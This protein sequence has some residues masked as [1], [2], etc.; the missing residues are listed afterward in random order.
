MITMVTDIGKGPTSYSKCMIRQGTDL[1]YARC[2]IA[3]STERTSNQPVDGGNMEEDV[4]KF[5]ND[6]NDSAHVSSSAA[7]NLM[8]VQTP[9]RM[10]GPMDFIEHMRSRY[11]SLVS[12]ELSFIL[13]EQNA[14]CQ[15]EINTARANMQ[16]DMIKF[17]DKLMASIS[18]RCICCTARGFT[19]CPTRAVDTFPVDKLRTPV[20]QK[21]PSV[22]L[23]MSACKDGNSA[24]RF[25]GDEQ[26]DRQQNKRSR[27]EEGALATMTSQILQFARQTLQA[28]SE[29]FID[30]PN[31]GSTTVFGQKAK[32]LPGRK[33]V[34]RSGF[35]TDPWTRGAVPLPP[36][37]YVS[38]Q[39]EGFIATAPPEELCRNFLVH[40]NP[41][42]LRITGSA[43]KC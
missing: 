2:N 31:D 40:E 9:L 7:G 18:K 10:L 43:L 32:G 33:Y 25:H 3:D 8:D 42:F 5:T 13:K 35:Q 16:A 6:R 41:R 36:Q 22:R 19:D 39:L 30:L 24:P 15:R 38:Q 21:I 11:P 34:F 12:T 23:D 26:S 29:M 28:I 14:K 37:P 27:H 17:V 1:C 4:C 20:G